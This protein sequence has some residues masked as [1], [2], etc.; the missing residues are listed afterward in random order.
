MVNG[1]ECKDSKI[2]E[3]E[4]FMF[5][6]NLYSTR[7]SPNDSAFFFNQIESQIPTIN[8]TFK[9]TCEADLTIEELDA[10]AQKLAVNK[11]PGSDGLTANFYHFFWTDIRNLLFKAIVECIEKN[12]L[13]A[14]MKQGLITLI[15]KPNKDKRVLDNLRPI[16]LLNTDYKIL[17]GCIAA[18]MKKGLEQIIDETQSGFLSGRSIHNNIRLVL[19]LID[20]S[21]MLSVQGYILFLDFYKAFDSV[22]HPDRKS[23]V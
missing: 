17:S 14:T 6:S 20:Y 12:D 7:F 10:V 23:V 4:V 19:D 21:Q 9:E 3:K 2:I 15:P 8:N 16:T 5:Y 1:L 11:A 22:E 13:T 18:R